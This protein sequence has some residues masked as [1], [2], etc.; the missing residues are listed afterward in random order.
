MWC[1]SRTATNSSSSDPFTNVRSELR[2]GVVHAHTPRPC[3]RR[4][5]PPTNCCGHTC[6]SRPYGAVTAAGQ[7]AT[8]PD[9]TAIARCDAGGLPLG[10]NSCGD[11]PIPATTTVQGRCGRHC[12]SWSGRCLRPASGRGVRLRHSPCL[13]LALKALA[14]RGRRLARQRAAR[15]VLGRGRAGAGGR[16]RRAGPAPGRD[17]ARA[18]PCAGRTGRCWARCARRV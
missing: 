5:R 17:S 9:R 10:D 14:G 18:S 12:A 7:A 8:G 6:R 15:R 4:D 11:R 13:P 1:R 16:A 2:R 3:Q